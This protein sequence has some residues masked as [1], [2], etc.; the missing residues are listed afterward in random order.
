MLLPECSGRK[1]RRGRKVNLSQCEVRRVEQPFS[2]WPQ[3]EIAR[4]RR[5]LPAAV[6]EYPQQHLVPRL[7]DLTAARPAVGP[8][9]SQLVRPLDLRALADGRTPAARQR[10]ADRRD[11]L[12]VVAVER[13]LEWRF[14]RR[15]E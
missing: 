10:L 11:H 8:L 13:L 4:A 12:L 7:L 2:L 3:L 14:R 15:R 6:L 9:Q 1:G 5:D